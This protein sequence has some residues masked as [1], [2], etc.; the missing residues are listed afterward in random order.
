MRALAEEVSRRLDLRRGLTAT[1]AL[2]SAASL[3]REAMAAQGEVMTASGGGVNLKLMPDLILIP[4]MYGMMH[5]EG[6]MSDGRPR[7]A[8]R[9]RH[10]DHRR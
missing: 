9:L 6:G 5:R 10:R 3:S 1:V 8:H 4:R 7:D 2:A